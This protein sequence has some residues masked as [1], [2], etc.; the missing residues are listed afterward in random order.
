MPGSTG[1]YA[2]IP[3]ASEALLVCSARAFPVLGEFGRQSPPR[4]LLKARI[5]A[6]HIGRSFD[7][8]RGL[9]PTSSRNDRLSARLS[10]LAA[11]FRCFD[12]CASLTGDCLRE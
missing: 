6:A 5:L 3:R 4:K 2:N 10:A 1:G 12:D 9:S 11:C 7:S 8:R